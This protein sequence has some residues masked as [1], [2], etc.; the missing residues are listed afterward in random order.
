[1]YISLIGDVL[2]ICEYIKIT[3]IATAKLT[4]WYLQC[5]QLTH[6]KLANHR[7]E[8][9]ALTYNAMLGLK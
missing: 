6:C 3:F 5:A 4:Q 7:M 1:M 2:F 9:A 8:N